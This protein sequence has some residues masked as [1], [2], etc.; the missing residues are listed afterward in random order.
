MTVLPNVEGLP[1][2]TGPCCRRR[3]G[4]MD[5]KKTAGWSGPRSTAYPCST[6]R[7]SRSTGRGKPLDPPDDHV[8]RLESA[9]HQYLAL[10][11]SGS[12]ISADLLKAKAHALKLE[13]IRAFLQPA[14]DRY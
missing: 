4:S 8:V 3:P 2:P 5:P 7:S 12:G 6:T 1:H 14:A 11:V 10:I 9:V 13:P